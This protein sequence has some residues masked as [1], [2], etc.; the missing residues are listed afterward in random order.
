MNTEKKEAATQPEQEISL[1][2][3][4]KSREDDSAQETAEYLGC[5]CGIAS[6]L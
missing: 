5:G 3:I 6:R 1:V 2:R 4:W